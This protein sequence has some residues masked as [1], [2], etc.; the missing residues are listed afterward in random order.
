MGNNPHC[1]HSSCVRTHTRTR[2]AEYQQSPFGFGLGSCCCFSQPKFHPSTTSTTTTRIRYLPITI[3][4]QSIQHDMYTFY[5][6]AAP[7][8]QKLSIILEWEPCIPCRSLARETLQGPRHALT[9]NPKMSSV[10][11]FLSPGID[12]SPYTYKHCPLLNPFLL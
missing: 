9:A 1:P 7:C 11:K 10:D 12:K 8:C 2:K 5:V 6:Q 4:F 3:H